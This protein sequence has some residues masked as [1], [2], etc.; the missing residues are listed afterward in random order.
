MKYEFFYHYISYKVIKKNALFFLCVIYLCFLSS[1]RTE[2]DLSL[3][4]IKELDT[5]SREELQH[6]INKTSEFSAYFIDSKSFQE[7]NIKLRNAYLSFLLKTCTIYKRESLPCLIQNNTEVYEFLRN[8]TCCIL[9]HPRCLCFPADCF[10]VVIVV[11]DNNSKN[12]YYDVC[13]STTNETLQF[14]YEYFPQFS[15]IVRHSSKTWYCSSD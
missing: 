13:F 7:S 4:P 3:P 9:T 14:I 10:S 8:K 15:N 12:E 5:I 6:K 1:C 2:W 11:P